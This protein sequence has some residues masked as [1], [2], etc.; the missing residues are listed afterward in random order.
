MTSPDSAVDLT[1]LEII[2]RYSL[3][4][5]QDSASRAEVLAALRSDL[6]WLER[7]NRS[8]TRSRSAVAER[9]APSAPSAAPA[10]K[11]PVKASAK[12]PAKPVAKAP[13]NKAP[14]AKPV[15]TAPRRG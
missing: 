2:R 4:V 8:A 13:A 11:A 6:E 12:A 3:A 5:R 10:A 9:P 14:A 1:S 15:K 7:G